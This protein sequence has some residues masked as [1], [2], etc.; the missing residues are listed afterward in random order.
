MP[1]SIEKVSSSGNANSKATKTNNNSTVKDEVKTE[2]VN[3]TNAQS[4][5]FFVDDFTEYYVQKK[6]YMVGDD[7][8]CN[9]RKAE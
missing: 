5:D 1:A 6:G 9:G 3:L 7:S 4:K 2:T 8:I